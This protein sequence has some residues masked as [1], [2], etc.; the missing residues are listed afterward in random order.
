MDSSVRPFLTLSD[1][2]LKQPLI[3]APEGY[4]KSMQP[5]QV[6]PHRVTKVPFHPHYVTDVA[7]TEHAMV[8]LLDT[9]EVWVI[10][11][12]RGSKIK[13]VRLRHSVRAFPFG[14]SLLTRP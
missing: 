4:D 6:L 3:P 7:I 11:N 9:K 1:P 2:E 12:D 14:V 13:C 10:T 8:W 5:V